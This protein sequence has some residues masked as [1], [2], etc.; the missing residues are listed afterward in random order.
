ML[1]QRQPTMAPSMSAS[2]A[3]VQCL[4]FESQLVAKG[5]G[6]DHAQRDAAVDE[7]KQ[8]S[9]TSSE[10]NKVLETVDKWRGIKKGTASMA[11]C[12]GSA[13]K[14]AVQLTF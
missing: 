6:I 1:T 11:R 5:N 9:I 3:E 10:I 14:A 4:T 12:L 7:L 13:K 2:P 8:D